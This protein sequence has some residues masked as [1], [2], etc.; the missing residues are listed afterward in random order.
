MWP[1]LQQPLYL[2]GLTI[3]NAE[4]YCY[5]LDT[6]NSRVVK[7]TRDGRF[8]LSWGKEGEGP[9]E[10]SEPKAITVDSQG[11]VY[12]TDG[13]YS[14]INYMYLPK[15]I[16]KFTSS[17]N[18]LLQ[19]TGTGYYYFNQIL[20]DTEGF[21]YV[22][23][24][25]PINTPL[26]HRYCCGSPIQKYTSEGKFVMGWGE[27]EQLLNGSF[28]VTNNNHIVYANVYA[29]PD[30][31]TYGATIFEYTSNGDYIAEWDSHDV[32]NPYYEVSQDPAVDNALVTKLTGESF[33]LGG[34]VSLEALAVDAD[35]NIYDVQSGKLCL[36]KFTSDGRFIYEIW[37]PH[38]FVYPIDLAISPDQRVF[39][40]DRYTNIQRFTVDGEFIDSW[41]TTGNDVGQLL[42]PIS[43]AIDQNGF[44]YV[45]NYGDIFENPPKNKILKF[46]PDGEFISEFAVDSN[47]LG[48]IAVDNEGNI[49]TAYGSIHYN[50]NDGLIKKFSS[51][52]ELISSWDLP[53]GVR[54]SDIAVDPSSRI[55]IGSVYSPTNVSDDIGGKIYIFSPDGELLDTFGGRG[56][57]PGQFRVPSGFAFSLSGKI[58]IGDRYTPRIQVFNPVTIINNSK[59]IILAG[60]GPFPGNNL[61]DATQSSANFTY[62]ALTLQGFFKETIY[63]LSSDT[64]LD[65]DLNGAADDVDADATNANLQDAITS[66]AMDADNLFIYLVDHGGDKSFRMSGTEIL[67]VSKLDN[68]IDQLQTTTNIKVTVIYDACESGS[69]VSSLTPPSGKSRTVIAST[70]PD[71][72]AVFVSQ[73]SI[74][75]SNYFWTNIFNGVPMKD[76]FNIASESLSGTIDH[77]HPLLDANSNGIANEPADFAAVENVFIRSEERRV[78]KECRSRWSPYH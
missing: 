6:E 52:G 35:G 48:T 8:V 74:S 18:F 71:E 13:A 62:H 37:D 15:R 19:W 77:Q 60:G 70:S 4:G 33:E 31:N 58:Y 49:Y 73:G 28:F 56:V 14:V 78:G 2:R 39:V 17:G 36:Q 24:Y 38:R 3:C 51:T 44:V 65:L 47:I 23:N 9:G 53:D 55:F 1:T 46:S 27:N 57:S 30:T 54:V 34:I 40:L 42:N 45:L 20:V 59:A 29:N 64:D 75:F 43:I 32:T 63:Y 12:V 26:V 41:G 25:Y 11:F 5:V 10:F 76:A 61:W 72:N 69:F 50:Y 7:V 68:W 67:T 22:T 21:V 16:Q 66:W